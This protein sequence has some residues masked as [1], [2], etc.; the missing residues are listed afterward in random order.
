[1]PDFTPTSARA[2]S[3]QIL[4]VDS[5]SYSRLQTLKYIRPAVHFKLFTS[6]R[7]DQIL[8]NSIW[9]PL[10]GPLTDWPLSVCDSRTIVPTRDCIATDVVDRQG[11]N[12]NYQVY[13][14]PSM[15]FYYLSGQLASEVMLFRQTDTKEGCDAGE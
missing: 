4:N 12:E 5:T 1:M 7:A 2:V 9:K 15:Q 6:I 10:Y 11:F 14:D 8:H 3:K 13:Y